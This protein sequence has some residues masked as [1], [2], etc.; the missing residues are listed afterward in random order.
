MPLQL[1]LSRA[2]ESLA[3]RPG[4]AVF[5]TSRTSESQAG[6][7][8]SDRAFTQHSKRGIMRPSAPRQAPVAASH[9]AA[10]CLLAAAHDAA[11][12][13]RASAA[14]AMRARRAAASSSPAAAAAAAPPSA[15]A[16]VA[17]PSSPPSLRPAPAVDAD[18]RP[19]T[20]HGAR[21][22]R[23][24]AQSREDRGQ[25]SQEKARDSPAVPWRSL[26]EHAGELALVS[27]DK[28]VYLRARQEYGVTRSSPAGLSC[29][30]SHIARRRRL[31]HMLFKCAAPRST[32]P[33]PAPR[34]SSRCCNARRQQRRCA[35]PAPQACQHQA[36]L[37]GVDVRLHGGHGADLALLRHLLQL[38]HVHLRRRGRHEHP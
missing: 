31:Q 33:H 35:A 17:A 9:T 5:N 1:P 20:L 15:A 18:T 26:V 34:Q 3:R 24:P 21:A 10:C 37:F 2:E 25:H 14:A 30:T 11:V 12:R 19:A 29:L 22:A 7:C 28:L 6:P 4:A 16:A 38:V 8:S 23:R 32:R 27:A 13:M 36:H